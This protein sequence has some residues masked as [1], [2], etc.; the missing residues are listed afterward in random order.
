[1]KKSELRKLIRESLG[2]TSEEFVPEV[3]MIAGNQTDGR[4]DSF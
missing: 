4:K 1:M 3:G 2:D